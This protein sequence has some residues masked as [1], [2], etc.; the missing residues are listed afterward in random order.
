MWRLALSVLCSPPSP[1]NALP[2]CGGG[3]G[4]ALGG[5]GTWEEEG[6]GEWRGPGRGGGLQ[7]EGAPRGPEL[8]GGQPTLMPWKERQLMELGLGC[9][10][11]K[12]QLT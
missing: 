5:E 12:T 10:P 6:P 4:G 9:S 11:W 7:G 3:G 1:G 8:Q 2:L